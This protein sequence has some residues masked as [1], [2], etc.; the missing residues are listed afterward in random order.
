[1]TCTECRGWGWDLVPIQI[2]WGIEPDWKYDKADCE[3]CDGK[4][5]LTPEEIGL[6]VM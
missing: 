5:Y 2:A 6:E 1:M 4:G 3:G